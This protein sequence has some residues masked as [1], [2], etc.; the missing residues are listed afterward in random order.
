MRMQQESS[1]LLWYHALCGEDMLEELVAAGIINTCLLVLDSPE[2]SPSDRN[3]SAG[4]VRHGWWLV[5][6]M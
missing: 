5:H 1:F 2:A 6:D 4:S 3:C